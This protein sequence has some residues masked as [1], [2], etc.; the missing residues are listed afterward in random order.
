MFGDRMNQWGT[1]ALGPL[2]EMQQQRNGFFEKVEGPKLVIKV[3]DGLFSTLEFLGVV[4]DVISAGWGLI[5]AVFDIIGGF[6][7]LP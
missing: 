7:D 6:M 2:E 4:W 5:S 3:L 1:V